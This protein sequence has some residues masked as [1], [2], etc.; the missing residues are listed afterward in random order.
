MMT[1]RSQAADEGHRSTA[2]TWEQE[3][4]QWLAPFLEGLG[5]KGRRRWAPL[6]MEGLLGP[7]DRKSVQPMAARIAPADHEQLH[8]FIATSAWDPAPLEAALAH[9]AERL[10]GGREAV[11]IVDDTTL[12]KQ[13]RHSVGV[14]RQYSGQAGKTTNCQCLVSLTLARGEVPVPIALRLFLPKEWTQAPVR[15]RRAAVPAAAC[16]ARTKGEIALA[17][18]DR[19]RA[20]G[21]TATTVLAD[22]GYGASATFRHALTARRLR[23][24]VGIPHTQKVFPAPVHV[25]VPRARSPRGRPRIHGV[26]SHVSRS[27]AQTLKSARWRSVTW[28]RGTRGPLRA[29]FTAV[30][31]RVAD[32]A[33]ASNGQHLPGEAAWLVGEQR[34]HGVRKY[35]LTNHPTG[36]SLRALAAVIKARWSCE[37]AHQQMKEELGLDHFE[38][39]GWLGL[40]HHALFSMLAFTFLQHLRLGPPRRKKNS[41]RPA[42]RT[43]SP[44]RAAR[45][46]RP[47]SAR[48]SSLSHLSRARAISLP[49]VKNLAK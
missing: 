24:A 23:W 22:A 11:L 40:H 15:L 12:L 46:P 3:L 49:T 38:G 20:A 8:H 43:L 5:H 41:A 14:A 17:E 48:S 36:T 44:R 13:G 37:Q 33:S 30:R 7:G 16:T 9:E 29:Q 45:T 28:R 18:L 39:R 26:P 6:Y 4:E 21:V 34:A 31:V 42:T 10:V 19:V 25:P 35:Y 27:A 32:G 1:R 2:S 47:R